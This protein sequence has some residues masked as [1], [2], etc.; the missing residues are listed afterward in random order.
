MITLKK[1]ADYWQNFEAFKTSQT[2]K[3]IMSQTSIA[4]KFTFE[5]MIIKPL[6][7]Y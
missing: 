2:C 6:Y 4:F 7:T 3:R 5:S 1:K